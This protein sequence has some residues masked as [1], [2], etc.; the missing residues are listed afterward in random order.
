MVVGLSLT[1]LAV[2]AATAVTAPASPA[3]AADQDVASYVVVLKSRPLSTNPATAGSAVDKVD[4][5]SATARSYTDKLMA[6]QDAVLAQVAAEPSYRYTV[7]LNGFAVRMTAA[8]AAAVAQRSDVLAVSRSTMRHLTSGS[9]QTPPPGVEQ[10]D[11]DLS[12]DVLGL[13]GKGGVW[14]QLGGP[15]NAGKGKVVGVIDTGIAY[16]NPSFAAA[17]MPAKPG[18]WAGTC[19]PGTGADAGDFPASACTDKIVGARYFYAGAEANGWSPD[20]TLDSLSPLDVN[21]HGSHTAG[22]AAG[23]EV[24]VSGY[25]LAGMA[26]GAHV[27][28]YKV[29]WEFSAEEAGCF[30]EDSIA[31]IEHSLAD[32]VDVLNFSISGDPTTYTD[33]V[34][35]AFKNAAAS[36]VFV[37]A[38]AGNSNEEGVPVAH[39]GP[40]QTTVGAAIHRAENGPVPSIASFSGRGPVAVDAPDQT[41]L[42]PDLGAPGVE[43]L[44]PVNSS[45][46]QAQWGWLTGTSMASPHI[47]GLGALLQGAHPDWSPMEVKSALLTSARDYA[48]EES[49]S[50]FVGGTGFVEPRKF[51]NPGLVFDSTEADWDAFLADPASGTQL[52]TAYVQIPQLGTEPTVVTRTLTNPGSSA[53]TFTAAYDGPATLSVSVDPAQV[54]VPAGGS[55]EVTI[56]VA[57]TG[58]ATDVWQQGEITWTGGSSAVEIPVIAR[59]QV[60]DPAQPQPKVERVWGKDRYGTAGEV[61]GLY[62]DGVDTVYIASGTGFADALAGSPA[63]SRGLPQTMAT[64]DGKA[65]PVLLVKN[66][67]IPG[68]TKAALDAI[69]P[70]NVIVL[71]GTAAV[72]DN[73]EQQLG[74]W[75]DVTRVEGK[76]RYE[77]AANLAKMFGSADKV[78]LASGEDK[79]FADA[80]TGAARAGMEGAPVLL[81]RPGSVPAATAEALT[82]LGADEVVVLGGTKA[83]SGEVYAQVGAD[84]R[85]SGADRYGTAVAV[86]KV[87]E[88]DVPVVY[89]ASGVNFPDA[90]AGSA[91][92]GSESVPVLLTKQGSL[93]GSTL[94]ELNRLDPDRVVILG[95]TAAVSQ[96]VEDQL[97]EYYPGW[98]D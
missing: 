24:S 71:G 85:L 21:G 79:A 73:V 27:A 80:L 8:E 82:Q 66:D 87:H 96:A 41:I 81:T 6:Q 16:D 93:P 9:V 12:P 51:L 19:Q 64:P 17:G 31:A 59:G 37:A 5:T 39:T 34:D 42:K 45:D 74:A 83:V 20:P 77:T 65:A 1:A 69:D 49:N 48:V 50:A 89:I 7:A 38:S 98:A 70:A 75:G 30:P 68:A 11:T 22:T 97:N 86:S 88:P 91:L 84:E 55:V 92:A 95:G 56:T 60:S 94:A 15:M 61:S 72:S 43:V 58:A 3:S 54:T 63:A 62:P 32:G 29:C 47:A 53:A 57:N 44:A 2:P 18:G 67:G 10:P 78:Y 26:P 33:P 23:R 40:W 25:N 52:N 46:G 90:L 13:R 14:E 36:G 76:D 4:T 28:A 35:L